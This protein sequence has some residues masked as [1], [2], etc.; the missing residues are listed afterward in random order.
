MLRE[1]VE[2]TLATLRAAPPLRLAAGDRGQRLQRRHKRARARAGAR[3]T[4]SV[5]ALV[6]T[7]KGRGIALREAW[8]GSEADVVSYMDVD[9]STDLDAPAG[10]GGDGGG[11]RLRRG[12]R[13]AAGA[14][15]RATTRS[16]KREVISRCYVLNHPGVLPAACASATRSAASRRS[17]AAGGGRGGAGDRGPRAG[18]S[19]RSCWCGRIRRASGWGSCRCVGWR[20]GTRRCTS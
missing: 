3:N 11:G 16:L 14:R 4:S 17:V 15:D 10:P 9:L 6:L 13:L 2:R 12:E 7:E 20:I 1:S 5:R 18:S 19:I 8:L